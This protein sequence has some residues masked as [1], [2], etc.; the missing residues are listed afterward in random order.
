MR[1]RSTAVTAAAIAMTSTYASAMHPG[2][3]AGMTCAQISTVNAAP[4]GLDAPDP[5]A[6]FEQLVARYR[7]LDTYHDSTDVVEVTTRSGAEPARTETKLAC[8][9]VEGQLRVITPARQVASHLFNPLR[10]VTS[11]LLRSTK[12]HRDE[13]LAPHLAMRFHEQPL[14]S[15]RA[16][17]DEGFTATDVKPVTVEDREMLSLELR[18]GDGTCEHCDAQFTLLVDPDSMLI[19]RIEGEQVLDDGTLYSMVM[20][21]KPN[22]EALRDAA[23]ADNADNTGKVPI[24]PLAM[25]EANGRAPETMPE[26]T[27]ADNT[28]VD[29]TEDDELPRIDPA[30]VR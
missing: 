17:V 30:Q 8:S 14:K 20:R 28:S 4:P 24:D 11:P 29:S 6:F 2:A 21:I 3:V 12:Q 22:L 10:S 15:F 19:E 25:P 1:C 26:E 16:G 9:I 18:S 7:L 27:P 5:V 23:E 13:W